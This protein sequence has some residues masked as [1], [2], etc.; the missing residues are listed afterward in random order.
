MDR[1]INHFI[2][3]GH[4]IIL[5]SV[6]FANLSMRY[7]HPSTEQ[8]RGHGNWM[9]RLRQACAISTMASEV[10]LENRDREIQLHILAN[11]QSTAQLKKKLNRRQAGEANSV[12]QGQRRAGTHL[13]TT[14]HADAEGLGKQERSRGTQDVHPG[15]GSRQRADMN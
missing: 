2:L 4:R 7:D 9:D 3:Q 8:K 15:E 5:V 14:G 10:V 12:C 11:R 1:A 6:D 13:I